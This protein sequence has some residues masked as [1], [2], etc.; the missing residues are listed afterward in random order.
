[1]PND[2]NTLNIVQ[3]SVDHKPSVPGE[4]CR[5][6]SSGGIIDKCA[7]KDKERL[8]N[9]RNISFN[10]LPHRVW[11]PFQNLPGIAMSRSV[12]DTEAKKLGVSCEPEIHEHKIQEQ[13]QYLVVASDG[14]W[15]IYSNQQVLNFLLP[16][17]R[18]RANPSKMAQLL[19]KSAQRKWLESKSTTDDI[20][21]VIVYIPDLL[22]CA[23]TRTDSTA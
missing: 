17:I 13:D 19:C 1:M 10:D 9:N 16:Y 11:R 3:L 15:D 7:E 5:I 4:R 23:S 20:S 2:P 6:E 14:I 22:A 12:G 21:C 18:N 8:T